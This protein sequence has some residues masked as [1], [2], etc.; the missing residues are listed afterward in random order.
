MVQ[1]LGYALSEE[2]TLKD[3]LTLNPDFSDYVMFSVVDVT[4]IRIK[5]VEDP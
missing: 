2:L 3:G 4:P 5:I 1:G